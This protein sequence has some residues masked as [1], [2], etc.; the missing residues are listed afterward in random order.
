MYEPATAPKILFEGVNSIIYYREQ[1]EYGTPVVV[2][3][4]KNDFPTPSQIVQFNNE[5]EF[6]KDLAIAGIRKAYKKDRINNRPALILEYFA[7]TTLKKTFAEQQWTFRDFLKIAINIAHTLG[8]IHQHHIIHKDIN[9]NNILVD[10]K[11]HQIKIID[12]GISSHI[13]TRVQD[14]R[15]PDALEGTLAYISP[16]QTGRM[17]RSVDY[18]SDLYS[19]GVAFYEV[20]AGKLPFQA[21]DSIELV[22]CH[23]AHRPTPIH[24]INA[25][26]PRVLSDIVMK[27]LEKNSEDR[28]QSAWGLKADL[29]KCLTRFDEKGKIEPFPIAAEDFSDNFKIPQKLYGRE[30]EVSVLLSAF[31]RVSEGAVE[32]V[33]I[34]GYSGVGKSALISEVHKPITEKRGYFISGKY[35]QYQRNIP[36]SG[37][38]QALSDLVAHVLTENK[39]FLDKWR[40]RVLSAIGT[41]GRVLT[42]VLPNLELIIGKQPEVQELPP[43]EARN[44]FNYVFKSF[45]RAISQQ[46]HPIVLFLDDLQW[47]DGSSLA[48]IQVIMNDESNRH[49]LIIGAYR[50]NEVTSAHPMA[51]M[52]AD[53]KAKLRPITQLALDNLRFEDVQKLVADTLKTDTKEVKDLAYLL[54]RKTHGNAFFVTQFLG[55]LYEEG[56]LTFD[57]QKRKWTWDIQQIEAKNTTENVVELMAS[58]IEKLPAQTQEILKFA[59]CI[60]DKFELRTLSILFK[61]TPETTFSHLWVAVQEG[62]IVPLSEHYRF[63]STIEKEEDYALCLFRFLHDR[64]Q[65]AVYSL[66]SASKRSELHYEAGKIL[67]KNLTETQLESRIFDVVNQLNVGLPLIEEQEERYDLARL[68]QAAGRKAKL[69]AAYDAAFDYFYAGTALV[70][71]IGFE[72]E[73]DLA[74][75]LYVEAAET[76]Y[77]SGQTQGMAQFLDK[78]LEKGKNI[79]DKVQAYEVRINY[80]ISCNKLDDAIKTALHVLRLLKVRFPRKVTKLHLLAALMRIKFNMRGRNIFS[81]YE[82][83]EM[84]DPKRLAAMR[85]LTTLSLAAF[86]AGS[87]YY[88]L[89][90]FKQVLLSIRY[91]NA[92]VSVFAYS[93]YGIILCGV[94]RNINAGYRFGELAIK[95]LEKHNTERFKARTYMVANA[96]VRHWKEPLENSLKPLLKAY[97]KGIDTGFFEYGTY[98]VFMYCIYRFYAGHELTALDKEVDMYINATYQLKQMTPYQNLK[99]LRQTILNLTGQAQ[100]PL[101]LVGAECDGGL[102]ERLIKGSNKTAICIYYVNRAIISYLLG[103]YAGAENHIKI[104]EPHLA[105]VTSSAGIPVFYFYDSL[106]HISLLLTEPQYTKKRTLKRI[107]NNLKL[108][109][110]WSKYAPTTH[111]HKIHLI[112]AELAALQEDLPKAERNYYLAIELAGK[113]NFIQE[114][115]LSKELFGRY[116]L[117]RGQ[118]DIAALFLRK[119]YYDY[120]LWGAKAKLD[121]MEEIYGRFI[122]D[123]TSHQFKSGS[124]FQVTTTHNRTLSTTGSTGGSQSGSSDLDVESLIKASQTLSQEVNFSELVAKMITIVIENAGAEKGIFIQNDEGRLVISAYTDANASPYEEATQIIGTLADE[125][126]QLPLS[127]LNYVLRT[128]QS[129]VLSNA[130]QDDKYA[131]DPYIKE[132]K[133]KSVLC[134][135]ISRKGKLNGIIYLE[136]NLIDNAFTPERLRILNM[137]SSQMSISIEN[138]LLYKN[139][140]QKVQ[141]RTAELQAQTQRLTD[142]IR[143]AQTI[144][145][146]ILPTDASLKAAF[147]EFFVI[148]R[149]K[150]IVSGDFYWMTQVENYTFAAVIDCTGHGVP[151]AF[152]SVIGNT[153]LNEIVN[154]KRICQPTQILQLLHEGIRTALKQRQT[155]NTDGM[156]IGLCRIERHET[157]VEVLYAGAKR[158]L[159]YTYNEALHKFKGDNRSIGG[160]LKKKEE[161]F[162]SQQV[163]L[164]R[165]DILYLS[166]DGFIDQADEE[167]QKFGTLRFEQL[168]ASIKERPLAEQREILE[169]QLD[170]HQGKAEQRDDITI[171]AIQL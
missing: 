132:R 89:I 122:K 107:K 156:D 114:E 112:E 165:G 102:E 85:I 94:L 44:R 153:L 79:L 57:F 163:A 67:R 96:L 47:A 108:F 144:Q 136:N 71:D 9:S 13:D 97:R 43:N 120:R 6:T 147:H 81:L 86:V 50:D 29:E 170:R 167:R 76:A 36:Y 16:E 125:S 38:I 60:G 159:Y 61:A 64:V 48:L 148:F 34:G 99:I 119:A 80:Y 162:N 7:G 160:L 123:D 171:F 51:A 113:H 140:E 41:N 30:N 46:Q 63:I 25:S 127:L 59:A 98:A 116:W 138:A 58:K 19:L 117:K 146:A 139:L 74:I 130:L 21:K 88:P 28:Y 166:T 105:S 137:L 84:K 17:N 121:Q 54:Y 20:L 35:D 164:L 128:Q 141:D 124:S 5:Y 10:L 133:P 1:S 103:D 39:E 131:L 69:S 118:E 56:L 169:N 111:L 83:P 143:Y 91:G 4:L 65:Q 26:V 106:I 152:M 82:L 150:D 149:P 15:S 110:K 52:V 2:K 75:A 73:Y 161:P 93:S 23:L 45:I 42:D 72:Q 14:L 104:A 40:K 31:Q 77:L 66:L 78:I 129:L 62:L 12:F 101:E 22:H 92:P 87:P 100:N 37:L 68:N 126:Q 49:L 32:M 142:S 24:Q 33:L 27:L 95:L 135:P 154:L 109:K 134:F 168:L 145:Q 8:E 70:G 157:W 3:V 115:A 11:S 18:R 55:A 158:P 151:G 90:V 53:L 155:D